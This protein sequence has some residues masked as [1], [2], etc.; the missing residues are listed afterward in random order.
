[1][2]PDQI[3]QTGVSTSEKMSRAQDIQAVIL[4]S[5]NNVAGYVVQKDQNGNGIIVPSSIILQL[6]C[7]TC[8][9]YNQGR[10]YAPDAVLRTMTSA[11][12]SPVC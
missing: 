12:R 8:S 11:S 5:Q 9:K 2:L 10:Q 7:E 1:M 4:I 6:R 3:I